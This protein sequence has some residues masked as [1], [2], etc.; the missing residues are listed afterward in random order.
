MESKS[1]IPAEKITSIIYFI[2]NE[3][4]L[5]DVDLA[6]LYGVETKVLNQAVKRNLDRFPDDFMFQLSSKEF[7]FLRSQTVTS[8][9]GG[10]R[11]PPY[12][13]TEQGVSMLSSVLKSSQ[14]IQV[15][16][17]IMRAFVQ[18]RKFLQSHEELA[19]QLKKLEKETTDKFAEQG[20]QIQIIFEAI[21][22]LIIEKQKPKKPIGF[23]LPERK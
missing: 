14:A 16:I 2:R 10:R 6:I 3:K 23:T 13:F 17:A 4:V 19:A 8:N 22:Q 7:E 9:W 5:L 15:N 18:M 20:K 11:Y 12:A 21:K 1:L